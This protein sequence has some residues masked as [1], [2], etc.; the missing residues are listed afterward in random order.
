MFVYVFAAA[1]FGKGPA[2]MER[3]GED[4]P[5]NSVSFKNSAPSPN[6]AAAVAATAAA[7]GGSTMNESK[8]SDENAA[9]TPSTSASTSGSGS[10]AVKKKR[11]GLG[12]S[13]SVNSEKD[14]SNIPSDMS[15]FMASQSNVIEKSSRRRVLGGGGGGGSGEKSLRIEA[16]GGGGNASNPG[17]LALNLGLEIDPTT[18]RQAAYGGGENYVSTDR[19]V[20]GSGS[21]SSNIQSDTTVRV[22]GFKIHESGISLAG[23]AMFVS[24]G[25]SMNFVEIAALG[26]GAS[27]TV[28][29]ALHIPT[30]TIVALKMLPCYNQAKR[31]SIESELA[32][33]CK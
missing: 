15:L 2:P 14:Y 20:A 5:A 22:G 12:L 4:S 30:L 16:G 24:L 32:V 17:G 8:S 13:I 25:G 33:L 28:V 3:L 26:A 11:P 6:T 31:A 21:G 23:G 19:K 29:E 7:M 1:G 18:R 9:P 27:G 10:G